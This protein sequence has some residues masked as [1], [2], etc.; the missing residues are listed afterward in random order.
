M[1][2]GRR[3]AQR[4]H[5]VDAGV[6]L[7]EAEVGPADHGAVLGLGAHGTVSPLTSASLRTSRCT[8]TAS[9]PGSNVISSALILFCGWT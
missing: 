1:L 7:V 2:P 5:L 6:V 9:L 4:D 3:R 8:F